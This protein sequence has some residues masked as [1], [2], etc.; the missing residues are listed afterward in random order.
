MMVPAWA[1][2]L[3]SAVSKLGETRSMFNTSNLEFRV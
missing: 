1:G 3:R 2:M